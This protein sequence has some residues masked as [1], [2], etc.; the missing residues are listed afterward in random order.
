VV[1]AFDDDLAL[2]TEAREMPQV[3]VLLVDDRAE[4]LFAL[5][6]SLE[7]LGQRLVRA[8]SGDAAL[9]AVLDE[10]FAVILMDV[11]MP[12]L[13][14]FETL[15]MLRQRDR[16]KHIPIIFLTAYPEQ[17]QLTR[18]YE[19]GAVDYISKPF[20]PETLRSKVS[21]FV[22]LRQ[23]EL[24]LQAA[25]AELEQRVLARTA[26]L[27]AANV[28]LEREI[29]ERKAME[30][31]LIEQAHHDALTGLA[32]RTL[33]MRH[34]DLAVAQ[35]RRRATPS[36]AVMMLDV[37]RF[38]V[39]NDSLGHLAGDELLVGIANRL[40]HC[41][42]E[43]DTAA[44]LGGDEFAVIIDGV[45]DIRDATR[46]AERFQR[47]LETPF[48][49]DGREVFATS[50][51]GLAMMNKR[52]EKGEELL[53]D[54]DAAMY[55]AKDAGRARYQVFDLEMHDSATAQLKLEADLYR[56]LER[57]E[58]VLHYQPIV[59]LGDGKIAAFEA[60]LRW[61]HPERG[62]VLPDDFI[63][64]AE[65]T[66]LIRPIGRWVIEEACR[67][68][69]AWG[70]D[71]I[72][73]N[74]NLS[75]AQLPDASL[76]A[77]LEQSARDAGI[78][79]ERVTLE[80]AESAMMSRG[81]AEQALAR[82]HE[83]RELGIGLALDDFGTGYSCLSHL[84]ELSVSMVKIDR[85]FVHRIGTPDERP[86]IVRAIVSLAHALGIAVTAEGVETAEQLERLRG[87]ACEHA[88]GYF[89]ARPLDAAAAA[90][91]LAE[92]PRW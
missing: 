21:V 86:E 47:A 7:P 10:Q 44:R 9:R 74:I 3:S 26:E 80:L 34:L 88:Q 65:E 20:E 25:H 89:F 5:E 22:H 81:S 19:S 67:Q 87:L 85:T 11:R 48:V 63:P 52:Y 31:K 15:A 27:A 59:T 28:A 70:D 62:L 68:L 79:P 39:I 82:L 42:R 17:Q 14:G 46:S 73:M 60:L 4:N 13:D 84:Q 12:G 43:V 32:N 58:L 30:H 92:P 18:S 91:L 50:S 54:A 51:I 41:L 90:A 40:S 53:R 66:T 57:R 23:N 76:A 64:L 38:K 33:L 77:T 71:S 1:R 83:I 56:A 35:S 61:N 55:R 36:F 16:T 78:A 8:Q 49:I 37:D 24:A 2:S 75:A 69:A 6:V 72:G 45:N 29:A